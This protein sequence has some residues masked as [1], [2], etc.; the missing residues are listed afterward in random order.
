MRFIV[1]RLILKWYQ[2]RGPNPL[3]EEGE[4]YLMG[5]KNYEVSPYKFLPSYYIL[6]LRA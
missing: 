1:F 6:P 5:R 3:M 2:T 4:E